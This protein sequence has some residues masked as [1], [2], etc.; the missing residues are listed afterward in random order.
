M[1]EFQKHMFG[2]MGLTPGQIQF[3]LAEYRARFQEAPDQP[4]T[5]E[6]FAAKLEQMKK[7]A[8][9]YLAALRAG[10]I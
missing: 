4:L 6:E 9:A 1:L 2:L 8:P 3:R 10:Q 7:E 5:E